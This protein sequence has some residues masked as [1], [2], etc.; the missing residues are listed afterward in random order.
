MTDRMM[1]IE[2]RLAHG[3][4]TY[5]DSQRDNDIRYLLDLTRTEW[6][7]SSMMRQMKYKRRIEDLEAENSRLRDTLE[8]YADDENY[9]IGYKH[10]MGKRARRALGRE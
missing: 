7:N 6:W 3:Y 10:V 8:F 2:R 9:D 4:E 5:V 1:E